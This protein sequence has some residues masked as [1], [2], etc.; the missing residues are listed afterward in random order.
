MVSAFLCSSPQNGNQFRDGLEELGWNDLVDR[1]LPVHGACQ[2]D[3]L[4]DGT[5]FCS[6]ISRMR[7]AIRS[8]PLATTIG[9][10]SRVGSYRNA[11]DRWVGLA[12]TSD[13]VGTAFIMRLR[14]RS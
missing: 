2:L 4:E 14:A 11:I 7:S 1:D 6:A 10:G 8:C 12:I 5:P 9:A 13:A 3:I